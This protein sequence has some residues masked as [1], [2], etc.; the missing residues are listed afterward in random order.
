MKTPKKKPTPKRA[1]KPT[2]AK[3][4]P[5]QIVSIKMSPDLIAEIEQQAKAAFRTRSA[6]VKY[7]IDLGMKHDKPQA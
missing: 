2:A 5:L 6:Q 3:P 1:A 4:Q 7:L